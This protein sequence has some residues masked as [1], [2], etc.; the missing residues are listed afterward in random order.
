MQ[1]SEQP[2]LLEPWAYYL[3]HSNAFTPQG[4]DTCFPAENYGSR[5]CSAVLGCAQVKVC[6]P[7]QAAIF[8]LDDSGEERDGWA[9]GFARGWEMGPGMSGSAGRDRTA[10][11]R[12][13]ELSQTK[14]ETTA[15][16]TGMFA[17]AAHAGSA[18]ATTPAAAASLV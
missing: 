6:D 1:T 8:D 9:D 12:G 4:L 17:L 10:L 3:S 18:G 13:R 14:M 7:G 16:M 15:A 5:L 11:W 2:P